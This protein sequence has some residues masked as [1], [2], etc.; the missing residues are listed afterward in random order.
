MGIILV[1]EDDE[2][3]ENCC[4]KTLQFQQLQYLDS[5]TIN[6]DVS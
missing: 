2:K 6:A 3:A 1:H 4:K 5:G